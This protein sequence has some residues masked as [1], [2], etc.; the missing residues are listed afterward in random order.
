M[1]GS[2]PDPARPAQPIPSTASSTTARPPAGQAIRPKSRAVVLP[3]LLLLLVGILNLLGGLGLLGLG[4]FLLNAP[5]EQLRHLEIKN[6]DG[7][8]VK[9]AP[10]VADIQFYGPLVCFATG[11]L[12]AILAFPV[13]LGGSA[14]MRSRSWFGSVLAAV[15]ALISPGGFVLFGLIAGF[16]ALAVLFNANVR[17]SFR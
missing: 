17:Q 5:Q 6:P 9:N 8:V 14:M 12:S 1:P 10:S 4:Y 11:V 13:M 16:W 15:L 3:G 7:S 2:S